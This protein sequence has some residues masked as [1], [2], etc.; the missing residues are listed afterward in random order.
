MTAY[1]VM[2]GIGYELPSRWI[3]VEDKLPEMQSWVLVAYLHDGR[4]FVWV[5]MYNGRVWGV[6]EF[7]ASQDVRYWQPLP[8]PPAPDSQERGECVTRPEEMGLYI[9]MM[10][11][12]EEG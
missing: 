11:A 6:G 8:E 10:K 12:R 7:E 5:G 1:L 3:R 4:L 2:D 9:G